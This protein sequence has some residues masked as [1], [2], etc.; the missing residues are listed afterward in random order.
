MP[1]KVVFI[2]GGSV[3]WTPTFANDLFQQQNLQ[4]SRLVLV[5]LDAD[6]LAVLTAYCTRLSRQYQTGWT[7]EDAELEPALDGADF[8]CLSISTGGFEAMH[9]DYTIPE[10]YGVYHTVGDT[11]GPGGIS[12][13]LRSVPVFA[14]V[15]RKM[16]RLCP[17]AWLIHVTNPLSQM[18]RAV[19]LTSKIRC[20]GL[21]H[22]Y[23]GTM[24]MLAGFLH[25]EEQEIHAVSVGINHN[26]WLKELTVRGE[27]VDE[28][29]TLERYVNYHLATQDQER[30]T[31]TTDDLVQQMTGYQGTM[32]YYL[33]FVLL[34]QF[35]CFPVSA[36]NHV[37]ENLPFYC[38]SETILQKYHIRRKGVLPRRQLQKNEK[39]RRLEA[40]LHLADP[41]PMPT[42]SKESFS[43]IVAALA[44][45]Q[46]T[47]SIVAMPNQ[48]QIGNL[49]LGTVV[50]TWAEVNGSGIFPLTSGD[51]PQA[52]AGWL[53]TS[54]EEQE[55]AVAAALSG[56][57]ELALRAMRISPMLTDKD[58][59]KPLLKDL[60]A[61][62]RAW[63]GHM[64]ELD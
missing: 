24:S 30:L 47:R 31:G 56:D 43:A 35:G 40:M 6:A 49:P 54:I 36:S 51:V 38:S 52:V 44:C 19:G 21:C 1:V 42:A 3:I 45:G 4:G 39:R 17:D 7:V 61:A 37:A 53:L 29:M 10:Q 26:T 50:E 64:K 33:N 16:E 11:S 41:L 23:A 60:M 2:G 8:V 13:T 27:P 20:A 22:N 55:L 58:A 18:T 25:A 63:L 12:R 57:P 5:D 14:D 9:A 32:E 62:N 28:K 15:A 46:T 34:E 59:A 48:G